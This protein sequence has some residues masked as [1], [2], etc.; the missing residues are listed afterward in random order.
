MTMHTM[1]IMRTVFAVTIVL[2]T[3]RLAVAQEKNEI[4][5]ALGGDVF[6]SAKA[7][8]AGATRSTVSSPSMTVGYFVTDRVRLDATVAATVGEATG[9]AEGE[10]DLALEVIVGARY[11]YWKKGNLR[12]NSGVGIETI[13][14][15]GGKKPN[16]GGTLKSPFEFIVVPAELQWWPMKGGAVTLSSFYEVGGLNLARAGENSY[17]V[18]LGLLIRLK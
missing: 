7:R 13:Q 12:L 15:P 16:V 14:G 10:G 18:K 3:S 9:G 17:G 11:S 8:Q 4:D 2:T 6:E 1:Q 5:F